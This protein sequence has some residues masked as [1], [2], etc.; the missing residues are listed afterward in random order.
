M[1]K[2]VFFG[3]GK[4]VKHERHL[5]DRSTTLTLDFQCER[6]TVD[7]SRLTITRADRPAG[8]KDAGGSLERITG[9]EPHDFGP[10]DGARLFRVTVEEVG[11]GKDLPRAKETAKDWERM[12]EVLEKI[13]EDNPELRKKL[14]R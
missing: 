5:L 12:A 13:F 11:P 8:P 7:T 4:I 2:L 1:S 6:G 14:D 3:S 10:V 9:H